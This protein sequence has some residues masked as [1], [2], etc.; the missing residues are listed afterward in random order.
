MSA[1]TKMRWVDTQT[2]PGVVVATLDHRL[3]DAVEI[4]AAIHDGGRHTPML[5]G[6]AGAGRELVVQGPAHPR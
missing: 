5:Q 6:R 3:D 2:C 1:W 4:G